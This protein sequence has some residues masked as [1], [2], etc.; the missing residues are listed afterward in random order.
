LRDLDE[1]Y[2]QEVLDSEAA[3]VT[4]ESFEQLTVLGEPGDKECSGAMKK[5][6]RW[7]FSGRF[8]RST[9]EWTGDS[10]FSMRLRLS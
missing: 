10:D 3:D 6:I 9:V 2:I 4:E 5:D 1:A 7:Q 8:F